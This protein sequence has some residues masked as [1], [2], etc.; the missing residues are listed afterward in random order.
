M[1]DQTVKSKAKGW[2]YNKFLQNNDITSIPTTISFPHWTNLTPQSFK[3]DVFKVEIHAFKWHAQKQL[4]SKN[5]RWGY[6]LKM[7]IKTAS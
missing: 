7:E 4:E 6:T 3:R 2:K 5:G 1:F